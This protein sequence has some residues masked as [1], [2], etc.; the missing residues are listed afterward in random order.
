MKRPSVLSRYRLLINTLVLA[1]S[2]GVLMI[3]PAAADVI[4]ESGGWTCEP[5]CWAWEQGK[6][7]TREVVCCANTDGRWFCI[8]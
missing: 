5:Q 3:S 8:E 4:P 2:L 6:G 1:L 7:C